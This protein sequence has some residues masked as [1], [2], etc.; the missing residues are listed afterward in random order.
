MK[1]IIFAALVTV[2]SATSITW[3]ANNASE[4]RHNETY[5]T[6]RWY[7]HGRY[8]DHRRRVCHNGGV[9]KWRYW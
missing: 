3:I 4:N 1:E 9:C 6:H 2:S 5:D 8:W 7:A